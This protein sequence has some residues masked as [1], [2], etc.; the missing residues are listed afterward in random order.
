MT[1]LVSV[2]PANV[3][4]MP[5]A[6]ILIQWCIFTGI[7]FILFFY[8]VDW[9]NLNE[10]LSVYG[11]KILYS[12]QTISLQSLWNYA[13]FCAEKKKK[14][15]EGKSQE[16]TDT[17]CALKWWERKTDDTVSSEF[18]K[19]LDHLSN[20]DAQTIKQKSNEIL[21]G[22]I[23]TTQQIYHVYIKKLFSKST[24]FTSKRN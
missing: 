23:K 5:M 19:P 14:F 9:K 21:Q 24:A 4:S 3:E 12:A 20:N 11:A 16:H 7:Y 8:N 6:F 1:K 15:S 10:K 18:C 13:S 17:I 22:W 2:F